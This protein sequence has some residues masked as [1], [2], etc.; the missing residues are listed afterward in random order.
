MEGT[1][2]EEGLKGEGKKEERKW[3]GILEDL[4]I[5][6]EYTIRVNTVVNGKTLASKVSHIPAMKSKNE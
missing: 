2:M 3:R 6:K 1:E 4:E 5:K